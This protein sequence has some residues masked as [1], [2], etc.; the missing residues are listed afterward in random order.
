MKTKSDPHKCSQ[1]LSS[2]SEYIDGTLSP[3][4]CADLEQ[5]L[6]ECENCTI[7]VDTLRKTISVVQTCADE[8]SLPGEVRTRLFQSLNLDDYLSKSKNV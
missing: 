8:D 1:L 2:I 3:Q 4:L 5:H 7:V 6:C